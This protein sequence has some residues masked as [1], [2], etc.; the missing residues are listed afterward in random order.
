MPTA[1]LR[2]NG[3]SNASSTDGARPRPVHVGVVGVAVREHDVRA[4][5]P[6]GDLADRERAVVAAEP[7]HVGHAGLEA[8]RLDR[9][10]AERARVV[11]VGPVDLARQHDHPLDPRVLD[12]LERRRVVARARLEPDLAADGDRL[13]A[14]LA[15]AQELLGQRRADRA[16]RAAPAAP[17][18]SSS[19]VV[20]PP[21][22]LAAHPGRRLEHH[23]QPD[24]AR[25]TPRR[26]PT[27]GSAGGARTA[28]RGGAARPSSAPCRGTGPRSA[29][30]CRARRAPCGPRRAG[31]GA[32][33]GCRAPGGSGRGAA[34]APAPPRSAARCRGRRRRGPRRRTAARRRPRAASGRCRAGGRP[35]SRAAARANRMVVSR[36]NGATKTTLRIAAR[37][38]TEDATMSTG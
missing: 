15:A 18:R 21:G 20:D 4:G 32:A 1:Y 12:D 36:G 26:R 30:R 28:A 13:E 29:G 35:A 8:E 33:R 11:V 37:C 23:R 16:R 5:R 38:S 14:V 17:P 7:L 3:P 22:R 6:R 27:T 31:P 19:S 2:S 24:L 25:R 10:H 34:R 9:A